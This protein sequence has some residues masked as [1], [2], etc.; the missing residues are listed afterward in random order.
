MAIATIFFIIALVVLI[1]L[2]TVKYIEMRRQR[3]MA[4]EIRT[5]ADAFAVSLKS[6]MLRGA[7]ELRRVPP[8]LVYLS[9][10]VVHEAALGTAKLMRLAEAQMHRIADMVSHKR[11]FQPREQRNEFLKQVGEIKTDTLDTTDGT[12]QNS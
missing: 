10:F 1:L 8:T 3:V 4:P 6:L 12:G 11:S 2:Y 7:E 5:R 9:R